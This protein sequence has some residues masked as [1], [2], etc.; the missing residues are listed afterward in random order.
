VKKNLIIAVLLLV[1]TVAFAQVPFNSPIANAT[2]NVKATVQQSAAII[3]SANSVLFNVQDASVSTDGDKAIS[4]VSK[5]SIAKGHG[6]VMEIGSTNLTGVGDG[7]VIPAAL[8]AY[9]TTQSAGFNPLDNDPAMNAI[10]AINTNSGGLLNATPAGLATNLTFKLAP[11]PTYNPDVYS[12][13]VT[14]V[15]QVL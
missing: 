7:Q 12:G 3:L 13:T 10:L 6:A 8:L 9:K 1:G 4:V 15:L 14:L 5:V 2:I 11:V